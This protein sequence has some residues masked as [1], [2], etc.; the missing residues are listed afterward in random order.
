MKKLFLTFLVVFLYS[1]AFAQGFPCDGSIYYVATNTVVGSKFYKLVI[2]GETQQYEPVEL[3]LDNPTGRHITCLGYNVRD[4]LIYGLDFNT[5]ELLRINPDGSIAS[6]GV[7]ENLDLSYE[8]YSGSFTADGLR[9]MLI[10]RNKNTGLDERIYSIR[11]NNAPNFYA[12]FFSI[13]SERPV[14]MTDLATDP[15]IGNIISFD[16]SGGQIIETDRSG[17]T[18]VSHR[19]FKRVSQV[20]GSLFFGRDAQLYGIGSSGSGGEQTTLFKIKKGNGEVARIGQVA[21]GRDTDACA[22]PYTFEFHKTIMPKET[23]GCSEITIDY[24]LINRAGIAQVGANLLDILPGAFTIKDVKTGALDFF[25]KVNSGVGTQTLELSDWNLLLGNNKIQVKAEIQS[26]AP[27]VSESQAIADNLPAAY[28]YELFSDDPQTED[29]ED[30]TA[31]EILDTESFS[32]ADYLEFSC[33]LDTAYLALPFAGNYQWSTGATDSVLAVTSAGNYRVTVTTECFVIEKAIDLEMRTEPFFVDLGEDRKV[34]L[35]ERVQLSYQTNLSAISSVKWSVVN[36]GELECYDC[37]RTSFTA[38][39]ATTVQVEIE[40]IRGCILTDEVQVTVDDSKRI[41]IPNSFSPND[42]G[43]NDT[44]SVLGNAG[45][46]VDFQV[47]DRWGS[48]V[49]NSFGG[50]VNE[51]PG[52]DGKLRDGQLQRGIYIY[53]LSVRFPDGE[54]KRYTGD[55]L[56][57]Y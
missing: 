11:M 49:Y 22:C 1:G 45:E 51:S 54:V 2:D 7:P 38:I 42:D 48:L 8:Y 6:L 13:V 57:E 40:D 39:A 44:F 19:P 3:P 35:G 37:D 28:N 43:V 20:F 16:E 46:V 55:I 18:S 9:Y 21:G 17:A 32:L 10:A 23:L 15:H 31:I 41:Y 53:T 24:N 33:Y 52:W 50:S 56:L 47:F 4:R 34:D 29:P 36:G 5:Y 30:P 25:V 27:G 26:V 12:G 14:A